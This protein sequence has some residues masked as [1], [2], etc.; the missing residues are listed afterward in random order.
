MQ[1]TIEEW[2]MALRAEIAHLK[3]YGSR[4]YRIVNGRL[5]SSQMT[6]GTISIL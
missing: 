5:I 6:S 1:E 2:Q 4:P 3:K